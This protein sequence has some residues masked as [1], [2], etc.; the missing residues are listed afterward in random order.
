L[1]IG[2]IGADG[3]IGGIFRVVVVCWVC[4]WVIGADSAAASSLMML[5]QLMPEAKPARARLLL[6]LEVAAAI[7][8]ILSFFFL[9]V[10]LFPKPVVNSGGPK[11]ARVMLS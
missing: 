8:F 4:I 2:Q 11:A 6:V 7:I 1:Q 3:L 5:V 10:R 9:R